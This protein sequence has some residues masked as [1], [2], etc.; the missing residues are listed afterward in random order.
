MEQQKKLT[1]EDIKERTP[2][3]IVESLNYWID[4]A[5]TECFSKETMIEHNKKLRTQLEAIKAII[6]IK[7]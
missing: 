3:Q 6:N 5:E 7:L 4:R 2:E 1:I